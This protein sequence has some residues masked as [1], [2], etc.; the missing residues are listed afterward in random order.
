MKSHN[1]Y[2]LMWA[3]ERSYNLF[4]DKAKYQICRKNAS[5][6]AIDVVDV[7]RAWL[8]EFYRLRN[9]VLITIKIDIFPL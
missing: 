2:D 9:K 5:M 1:I 6:S 3:F 8:K 4:T 7:A